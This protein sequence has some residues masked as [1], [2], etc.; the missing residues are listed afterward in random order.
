[1]GFGDTIQFCRYIPRVAAQGGK[2]IL[3]CQPPLAKLV[4]QLKGISQM[5]FPHQP[6]PKHDV[7]CPLLTLPG[8]MGTTHLLIPSDVPYLSAEPARAEHWRTRIPKDARRKVGLV[9][10]GQRSHANDRN[11]SMSLAQLAPLSQTRDVWF[12]SLQKGGGAKQIR[13]PSNTLELAN[14]QDELKDF[15]DT[16]A[17]IANLD[18]VITVDTSVA[19][20]A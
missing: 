7:H 18:L 19:H 11:R 15:S 20:L 8:T 10:A 2:L 5:I 1:Q 13:M 14:W 6:I 16:A 12:C 4:S 3:L 9:W 17:L